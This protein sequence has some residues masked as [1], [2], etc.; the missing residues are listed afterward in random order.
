M[1]PRSDRLFFDS[2]ADVSRITA[3]TMSFTI[4]VRAEARHIRASRNFVICDG[5]SIEK[6]MNAVGN[7]LNVDFRPTQYD[8]WEGRHNAW[9]I[10]P[11]DRELKITL[12]RSTC[13]KLGS[14]V[15]RTEVD[16]MMEML[17]NCVQDAGLMAWN[18]AAVVVSG[19]INIW[20]NAP[21][22]QAT[23]ATPAQLPA[24]QSYW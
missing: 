15:C 2:A 1:K 16:K 12:S 7:C 18:E 24:N 23:P 5:Y 17:S 9:R 19:Q 11:Q 8:G 10:V 13:L 22:A 14:D 21:F 4:V 3:K 20:T 6:L